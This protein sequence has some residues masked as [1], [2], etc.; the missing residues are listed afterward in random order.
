[1]IFNSTITL[2]YL[3]TQRTF[4]WRLSRPKIVNKFPYVHQHNSFTMSKH[5]SRRDK[6]KCRVFGNMAFP[7]A[8]DGF[9]AC[10]SR[11]ESR[12]C[13]QSINGKRLRLKS[14]NFA[15]TRAS[16]WL[17]KNLFSVTNKRRLFWSQK[18]PAILKSSEVRSNFDHTKSR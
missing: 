4:I 18:T 1:M 2:V 15:R 14:S 7:L 13:R 9:V 8:N 16:I 10:R 17:E 3:L 12:A 11:K 6:Y 5:T